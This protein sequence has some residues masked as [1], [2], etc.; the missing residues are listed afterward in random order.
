MNFKKQ[1]YKSISILA[2]AL[3]VSACSSTPSKLERIEANEA[4]ISALQGKVKENSEAIEANT[5]LIA[6]QEI[7]INRM[8]EKSQYK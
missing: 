8:F 2:L 1:V 5:D 4:A 6:D 7:K 3:F